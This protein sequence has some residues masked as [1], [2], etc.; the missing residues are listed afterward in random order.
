MQ[1]PRVLW[2]SNDAVQAFCRSDLSALNEAH[3][4]VSDAK[5]VVWYGCRLSPVTPHA[6][7]P[8]TVMT[9]TRGLPLN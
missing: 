9:I 8:E 5:V 2:D 7:R 1:S 6:S 4:A 3:C